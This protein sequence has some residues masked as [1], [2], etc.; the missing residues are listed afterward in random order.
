LSD[1]RYESKAWISKRFLS[2]KKSMKEIA[3]ECGVNERTIRR[4]LEKHGIIK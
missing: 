4:A 3:D 2:E 1:K